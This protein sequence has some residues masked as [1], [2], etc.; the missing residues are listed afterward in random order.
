MLRRIVKENQRLFIDSKEVV[1]IQDFSFNYNLP[2][3]VTRYLGMENVIFSHS[4]PVIAEIT[5]NKLLIDSDDFINYTGDTTFNGHLEYK[6]KYFA[7]NSGILNNY[8]ISC[9]VNQIPT[10][11]ANLTVLGEFGEGVDKSLSLLPKNDIT[12]ADYGDIEIT[13]NDFEFNR[14]QNFTL[15][16]DT[17]RNILYQLGNSYPFQIVTN[18]P[19]ITNL[20]FG[21]KVDDYQ[22][23]NIRD[24]LCQYKIESLG[25]IFKDF[26]NPNG[27][28]ILSFNFNEAI[29]LGES[30]QGSVD[31]SSIVN[32]T[33]QAFSKP[34]IPITFRNNIQ[35][36]DTINL[37]NNIDFDDN[38]TIIGY[39]N[40]I[41]S[42]YTLVAKNGESSFYALVQKDENTKE[43][44]INL[45][46]HSGT[47]MI[48]RYDPSDKNPSFA[49]YN[50]VAPNYYLYYSKLINETWSNILIANIGPS[51]NNDSIDLQYDPNDNLP[52]CISYD[53]TNYDLNYYKYNGSSFVK[54]IISNGA[55]SA[56]NID[57]AT[58]L[59]DPSDD[60]P[61]VHFIE[62]NS[63]ILKSGK[64]NGSSW[65]IGNI[66]TLEPNI[67]KRYAI[68]KI[69][70]LINRPIVLMA[71]NTT[72]TYINYN[73][74]NNVWLSGK[75]QSFN[76]NKTIYQ[77]PQIE[78]SF[79][80]DNYWY[81]SYVNTENQ[82]ALTIPYIA[83]INWSPNITTN[84]RDSNILSGAN[85]IDKTKNISLKIDS[86]L[87]PIVFYKK[88][89]NIKFVKS[90][91]GEIPSS[92]ENLLKNLDQSSN[93]EF[94]VDFLQ[95]PLKAYVI[96]SNEYFYEY[97]SPRVDF[98][99]LNLASS[100]PTPDGVYSFMKI[101][102]LTNQPNFTMLG[103]NRDPAKASTY[104]I[105]FCY[106]LSAQRT[107]WTG[108]VFPSGD[109]IFNGAKMHFFNGGRFD[110]DKNTN[111]VVFP[112]FGYQSGNSSKKLAALIKADPIPSSG[113]TYYQIPYSGEDGNLGHDFK[114]NPITNKYCLVTARNLSSSNG[115]DSG[116]IYYEM[117]PIT[118]NWTKTQIYSPTGNT[119]FSLNDLVTDAYHNRLDFKS[120]GNPMVI[121]SAKAPNSTYPNRINVYL[122]EYNGTSWTNSILDF[123]NNTGVGNNSYQYLDFKYN[124]GENYYG[125]SYTQRFGSFFQGFAYYITNQYGPKQKYSVGIVDNYANIPSFSFKKYKGE[126]RPFILLDNGSNQTYF[127]Y[128]E[129]TTDLGAD[130]AFVTGF[131][132]KLNFVSIRDDSIVIT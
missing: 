129:T 130:R 113:Y 106:P 126:T 46:S 111:Q 94:G 86:D 45:P 40:P 30:Y 75:I 97:K 50:Y 96:R 4:K 78:K 27:S 117:D 60:R 101:N 118:T 39:N 89:N 64:Y 3:D 77:K 84:S 51:V 26:K 7:F 16:I 20:T 124:S 66:N 35:N 1:G 104:E 23:K 102:P 13:L 70:D 112:L 52:A 87:K 71:G 17:N 72:G 2:I 55:S 114:V 5:V 56:N 18:P 34:N 132:N 83:E 9:A 80:N 122:A 105:D 131:Q 110:F 14:L 36:E 120:D 47:D 74:N 68:S 37:T 67:N 116:V 28:P 121:F 91:V 100:I 127:A 8:S 88:D 76:I 109:I 99:E 25:I 15:T 42:D 93:Y 59:F 123:N 53:S 85:Y 108:L 32:L 29:F 58:L 57:Y 54:T 41:L 115:F 125:L 33:Y 19:V 22:V 49:Y 61:L 90:T 11:T 6:D 21:I 73:V 44:A 92:Q 31:D 65:S 48:V 38:D 63:S 62:G 103:V 43:Y 98:K 119:S 82:L 24:L 107:S 81:I 69:D 10:L 128:L 95:D 12:I 79:T